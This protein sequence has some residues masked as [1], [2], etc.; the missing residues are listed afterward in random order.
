MA[1]KE[2][3]T[4]KFPTEGRATEKELLLIKN[5]TAFTFLPIISI[6]NNTPV[7]NL[8]FRRCLTVGIS[9]YLDRLQAT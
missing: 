7:S 6:I 9:V 8:L 1:G 3:D 5:K 2:L 4:H